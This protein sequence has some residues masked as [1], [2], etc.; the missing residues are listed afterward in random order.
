LPTEKDVLNKILTAERVPAKD[1]SKEIIRHYCTAAQAIIHP[2]AHFSL[3]EILFHI[4]HINKNSSFGAEDA[5]I[6]M[7]WLETPKG[8]V[9]VPVAFVGDNPDSLNFWKKVI[10][11]S[12][13]AEQNVQLVKKEE[14]QIQVH[15]NTFFAGW[16]VPI[17]LPPT[18]ILP[19][20]CIMLEGYGNVNTSNTP[21]L[22][23]PSGH[24]S[25]QEANRLEALVTF[26]HPS[27]KYSGPGTD[28]SI[29]RELMEFYPP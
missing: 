9:Y 2:P 1:F 6:I 24:K 21:T 29:A 14:L 26:L 18:L 15:G 4:F 7:P 28:G 25:R 23:L 8:Y 5:M 17:R 13:P 12:T 27:S 16:T 20:S 3:P 19:P 10:V 11:A 22:L